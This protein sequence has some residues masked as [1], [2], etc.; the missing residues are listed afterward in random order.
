MDVPG[1][2]AMFVGIAQ[3]EDDTGALGAVME[4]LLSRGLL[5]GSE[6][7]FAGF[8]NDAA[9]GEDLLGVQR[10]VDAICSVLAARDVSPPLAL[11]LFGNWGT[12]KSFFMELMRKR[13]QALSE[14]GRAGGPESPFCRNVVQIEFNVW[15]YIDT[16]LW[17]SLVSHIFDAIYEHLSGDA[18]EENDD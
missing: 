11:G 13:I 17:A 7:P 6:I 9:A 3:E 8:R 15:H 2:R 4:E 18:E 1:L 12:G 16:S 14:A 5:D 10:D